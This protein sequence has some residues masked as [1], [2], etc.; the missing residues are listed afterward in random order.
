MK[1]FAL[2]SIFLVFFAPTAFATTLIAANTNC[3]VE[4]GKNVTSWGE[5]VTWS[6]GCVNGKAT[7]NGV[8]QWQNE[9]YEGEMLNG[10]PHG[11]GV[12]YY[13]GGTRGK[14]RYE[15]D[16]RNGQWEG[17]GIYTN[18][19]GDRYEGSVRNGEF[20]N[21]VLTYK[22]GRRIEGYFEGKSFYGPWAKGK[23]KGVFVY[24]NGDRYEGDLDDGLPL[25]NG[26][27][28]YIYKSGNRYEGDFREG[29]FHGKGVYKFTDGV[30]YE[31]DFRNNKFH[32]NG[33][34]ISKDGTSSS[35]YYVDDRRIDWNP[36]E[37][38]LKAGQYERSGDSETAKEIYEQLIQR[39]SSSQWA[40]KASD[41][42]NA[43]QRQRAANDAVR[44]AA[45]QARDAANQANAQ[46]GERAYNACVIE[47]R[48]CMDRRG[49]NCWRDCNSLR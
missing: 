28:V 42:L 7:G 18:E 30:R 35:G 2:T 38:Y 31:G 48:A 1:K 45:N 16:W 3:Q 36:Q 5:T 19:K 8:A 27:G 23:G 20:Y 15:G 21:G 29:L 11:K 40:V 6:G 41:Q 44:D 43:D 9:R 14:S 17:K 37:M 13:I 22:N 34:I 25:K 47:M 39:F 26:K 49:G 33:A 4:G 24:D 12:Y 10:K 32:G 46:A